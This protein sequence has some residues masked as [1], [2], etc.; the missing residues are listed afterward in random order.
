MNQ[1]S[2]SK[3]NKK[4]SLIYICAVIA[5][6][7]V[8]IMLFSVIINVFSADNDVTTTIPYSEQPLTSSPTTDFAVTP[9]TLPTA[10]PTTFPPV[11]QPTAQ[12]GVMTTVTISDTTS[13]EK[14]VQQIC[15]SFNNAVNSVKNNKNSFTIR[16]VQN[17]NVS[18]TDFSLPAPTE[19]INSLI[20][21]VVDDSETEYK[22]QNGVQVDDPTHTVSS[23]I[24]PCSRDACVIPSNLKVAKSEMQGE[25]EVIYLEFVPDTS[26]FDG[27]VTAYPMQISG[28]TD[29]LDFSV[30]AMGPL[31]INKADIT[32]PATTVEAV[33]DADGR[34]ETLTVE[35]PTVVSCNGGMGAFTADIGLDINV[36][37]VFTIA[38]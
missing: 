38:Y 6:A 33:I 9:T 1:S 36:K 2:P 34:L 3:E 10:P 22:F 30:L 26:Y 17:V 11:S 29:P 20:K 28:A 25:K 32:Y 8:C 5:L 4:A 12:A 14:S 37:T 16:R 13:G 7:A 27:N 18:L 15:D 19:T 23:R 21:N 35:L 31:S 24:S